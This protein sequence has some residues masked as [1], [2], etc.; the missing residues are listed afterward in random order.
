MSAINFSCRGRS[1]TM[2]PSPRPF[3]IE[4]LGD[5]L[6]MSATGASRRT[7][8]CTKGPKTI[9]SM[10]RIGAAAGSTFAGGQAQ[11]SRQPPGGARVV[12]LQGDSTARRSTSGNSALGAMSREPNLFAMESIGR[13]RA[14]PS[15]MDQ[16]C[17]PFAPRP[18]VLRIGS[19]ATNPS[20]G[21]SPES[22]GSR[23]RK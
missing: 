2:M 12:A 4:P 21:R 10:Y 1:R 9:C 16:W 7:H 13:L 8:L 17:R 23:R 14:L 18:S 11:Q 6:E 22:H 15:T 5:R 20:L 19:T 3:A